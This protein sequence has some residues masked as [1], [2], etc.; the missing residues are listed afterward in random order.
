MCETASLQLV[1]KPN[2]TGARSERHSTAT[3]CD[4]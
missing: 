2:S 4:L 1:M 3:I